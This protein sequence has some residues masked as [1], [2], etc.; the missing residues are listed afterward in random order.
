VHVYHARS[1]HP[2][3]PLPAQTHGWGGVESVFSAWLL[4]STG[5][6]ANEPT[7]LLEL[8][9]PCLVRILHHMTQQTPSVYPSARE[10]SRLHQLSIE[11]PRHPKRLRYCVQLL[12][13]Q[14]AEQPQQWTHRGEVAEHNTR[15][16]K[17][18]TG[19]GMHA[20]CCTLWQ[21]QR[22]LCSLTQVVAPVTSEA[23][24]RTGPRLVFAEGLHQRWMIQTHPTCVPR[25]F[26]PCWLS[27]VACCSTCR[28]QAGWK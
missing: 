10:H 6:Q 12:R 13:V 16:F 17:H 4:Y 2:H 24:C 20:G 22:P 7:T 21:M 1:P 5:M 8:P 26:F 3:L 28:I 27:D 18:S 14:C 15:R 9:K 23:T 19:Q 11:V 25:A